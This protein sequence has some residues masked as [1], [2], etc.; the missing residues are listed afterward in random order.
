M[1]QK[2]ESGV[3]TGVSGGFATVGRASVLAILLSAAA[4]GQPARAVDAT[5]KLV[6]DAMTKRIATPSHL[7]A[8]E[9]MALRDSKPKTSES[10]YAGG[11]IYIQV[12]GKWSR[13]PLSIEAMR[14]QEEE[15]QRNVKSMTCRYLRDETV[16]GEAAAVYRSQ[17]ESEATKSD[18]TL[19]VSKR[20][21]LPLRNESA[22]DIG[23]GDKV[24]LAIRY[25][26]A[27]VRPPA[28]VK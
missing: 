5:C 2:V 9:S 26:Y 1:S 20:T 16:N 25:D 6:L 22:I 18:S 3:R 21:G 10:I 23:G 13:S 4:A 17:A 11:A 14:K 24:H 12:K 15:N 28:G 19:W 8:T 7:Y 27:N